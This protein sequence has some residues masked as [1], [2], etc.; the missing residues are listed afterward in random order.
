MSS[1]HLSEIAL[2]I[3]NILNIFCQISYRVGQTIGL[4]IGGLLS[5]PERNFYPWFQARFWYDHP[6]SLPCFV[7]AALAAVFV[8]IGYF[9][10]QEVSISMNLYMYI[11]LQVS[12]LT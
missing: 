9:N 2:P 4:P 12:L 8:A 7:A 1:S 10:M 6:F 11:I 5:H 3:R